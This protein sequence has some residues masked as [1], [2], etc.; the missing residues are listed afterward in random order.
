MVAS[1]NSIRSM[2]GFGSA[3]AR[4]L[5]YQVE[6]EIRSVNNRYLKV[7][8]HV[9]DALSRMQHGLEERVRRKLGRGSIALTVNV[10]RQGA[11]TCGLVNGPLIQQLCTELDSVQKQLLAA[12]LR[13]MNKN[14]FSL[15]DLLRIDG[16]VTLARDADAKVDVEVLGPIVETAVDD[17][18]A[19]LEA[20]Q[21]REGEHLAA[22]LGGIIES[23]ATVLS[24]VERALPELNLKNRERYR[25]RL[26]E[27]L[28]G[29]TVQLGE[30]D[31]LREI[32]ILAEKADITEEV[33]RLRGHLQQYRETLRAAG[34]VGRKLDF[35]TQEML[36][37]ANTMAAK[38]N[39]LDVAR[40]VVDL[41]A[42]I[43]RLR[44]QSQ[45]IE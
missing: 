17:A 30:G 5:G 42:D 9:P 32:A 41:R 28:E 45:N 6:A 33:G 16:V 39:D 27:F 37:E 31:V 11:T 19:Q 25:A 3:G 13:S 34:R 14:G 40:Q 7:I 4:S 36:R 29:S 2:T 23:A 15:G 22:E 24:A 43:D 20:M 38:I 12:D 10:E 44:E 1:H 8:S 18:L 21:T 35:L 26:R